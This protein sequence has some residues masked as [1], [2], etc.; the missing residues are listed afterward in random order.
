[1]QQTYKKSVDP[2]QYVIKSKCSAQL[3]S[4]SLIE[5]LQQSLSLF[6]VLSQVLNGEH[7]QMASGQCFLCCCLLQFSLMFQPI[8]DDVL[9]H[10]FTFFLDWF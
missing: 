1:M 4:Q 8:R 3:D 5:K 10:I 6:C 7:A 9:A 2:S